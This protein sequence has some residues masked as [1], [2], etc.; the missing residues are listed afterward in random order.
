M[1]TLP[2]QRI[3]VA[4]GSGFLGSSMVP[5]LLHQ[6]YEAVILTR[7]PEGTGPGG[8]R[9]V[10]WNART[11]GPWVR[12]LEGAAAI[13]NLVGR[14]VDCRKTPRNRREIL[15]SRVNSVRA[16][17]EGWR[18]VSDPPRV[19]LQSGTAHIFGDTWDEIL[20]ESSLIGEGLAPEVGTAWERALNEAEL[21]GCRRVVF[22]I[23][24]VMGRGGGALKTLARLARWGLGGTVGS[25]RQY[26]SWIHAA[27]LNA[28]FLR[29][30]RDEGM[31]GVYV[32]TSPNPVTNREFMSEL[33]RAVGR[34][35]SPPVP[36]LMVRLGSVILRTDPEL[37]LLGRRCVPTRLLREG[38]TFRFPHLREALRDLLG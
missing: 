21:P 6:G 29:G 5:D 13:I 34:P 35:W 20:D 27:D 2:S 16:L 22:R 3:I 14:T 38:F 23:S 8:A 28:L 36:G 18:Q 15:E 33:R 1:M 7:G 32:A 17:A 31:S 11:S 12:E 4:G 25:G 10:H 30:L 26:I 37:A 24:F 19:W 9:L